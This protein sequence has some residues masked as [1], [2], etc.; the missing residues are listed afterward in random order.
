M[1]KLSVI[2]G[3]ELT[4]NQFSQINS[5]FLREFQTTFPS[6]Q[7]LA[8]RQFFLLLR[9]E[10]ILAMGQLLPIE[11]VL[12]NGETFSLLGIGGIIANEKSKGYGKQIMTAIHRHLIAK[13]KT[14]VGF[15]MTHNKGFYEKCGFTVDT[16]SV[17]R[18]IYQKG[19]KEITEQQGQIIF[20]FNGSDHFMEKILSDSDEKVLLP[21]PP[22]W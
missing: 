2:R 9:G 13:D 22:T 7:K 17:Q 14:G 15:C 19:G 8:G 3:E 4:E 1:N 21:I 16:I 5:A 10:K 6:I 18:F 11:P 20:Y 12:Y